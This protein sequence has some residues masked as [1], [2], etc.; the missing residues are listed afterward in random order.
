MKIRLRPSGDILGLAGFSSLPLKAR[1]M[2]AL[3]KKA[4]HRD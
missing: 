4:I 3:S 2:G 1:L